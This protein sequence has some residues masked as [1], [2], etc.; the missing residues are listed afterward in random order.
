MRFEVNER[1]RSRRVGSPDRRIPT[2]YS[3]I[4]ERTMESRIIPNVK[5]LGRTNTFIHS[6]TVALDAMGEPATYDDVMGFSGAAFRLHFHQP[7]WCPSS[8]D[9]T[10][11]FDHGAPA[12]KAYGHTLRFVPMQSDDPSVVAEAKR[13]IL[14]SVD[15]GRPLLA[16]DLVAVADWGFVVGYEQNGDVLLCR[17]YHGDSGNYQRAQK[18]PWFLFAIDERGAVP[19]HRESAL[20]SLDI[21]V[22]LADTPYYD[23]YASGFE[24]YR[25]WSNDLLDEKRFAD[26]TPDGFRDLRHTNAWCY[27]SLLDARSCAVR[28]L[29]SIAGEFDGDARDC[30]KRAAAVYA[31]VESRLSEG[32]TNAPW[33]HV[34]GEWTET[35]RRAESETLTHAMR[36]ERTAVAWLE[37]AR[38]AIR[39]DDAEPA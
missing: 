16:I 17:D 37:R 39:S 11:G 35:M 38:E 12:A 27:T 32:R 7:V 8:P 22:E 29:N 31:D 28:Y 14:A 24:A 6:L 36:L 9:A 10:C 20:R 2:R 18:T 4:L 1:D 19:S 26:A 25:T 3:A 21:A 5:P 23:K 15:T 13:Q 34:P 30:L 33:A